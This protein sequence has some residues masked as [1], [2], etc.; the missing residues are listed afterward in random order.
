MYAHS[1][2]M[3][4]FSHLSALTAGNFLKDQKVTKKSLLV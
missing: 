1:L 4:A 3:A 2:T